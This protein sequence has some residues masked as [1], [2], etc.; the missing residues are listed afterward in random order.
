MAFLSCLRTTSIVLPLR[1]ITWAAKQHSFAIHTQIGVKVGV[2]IVLEG[3][4]FRGFRRRGGRSRAFCHFPGLEEREQPRWQHVETY[5][6]S[7]A[8]LE[9]VRRRIGRRTKGKSARQAPVNCSR[10]SERLRQR[11]ARSSRNMQAYRK[12][13]RCLRQ[14]PR[15]ATDRAG[16]GRGPEMPFCCLVWRRPSVIYAGPSRWSS[17]SCRTRQPCWA[18]YASLSTLQWQDY[19]A[20]IARPLSSIPAR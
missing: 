5:L 2:G 9:A 16:R 12:S 14:H 6:G 13:G 11:R 3:K 17:A 20:R 19:S 18:R 1:N 4:L 10:L 15:S 8:L 7:A